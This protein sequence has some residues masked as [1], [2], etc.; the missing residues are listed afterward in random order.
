[1]K[2]LTDKSYIDRIV[3]LINDSVT[4]DEKY[5]SPAWLTNKTDAGTAHISIVASNGDAV[6]MTS[7]INT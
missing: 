6:S 3:S 4:F 1:M 7:T 2:N 5:Y